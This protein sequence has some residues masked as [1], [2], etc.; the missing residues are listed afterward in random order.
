MYRSVGDN[1]QCM[2]SEE[3]IVL[4]L[5]SSLILLR[6][7]LLTGR[8]FCEF[9]PNSFIFLNAIAKCFL[10]FSVSNYSYLGYRNTV[11]WY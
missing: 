5:F 10:K 2:M 8:A 3:S 9:I 6:S 7:V 4:H 11:N 1:C